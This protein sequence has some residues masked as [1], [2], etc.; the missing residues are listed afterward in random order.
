MQRVRSGRSSN[1]CQDL[2]KAVDLSAERSPPIGDERI[3]HLCA[4]LSDR[5]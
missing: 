1:Y 5:I 3:A 2:D 4:G